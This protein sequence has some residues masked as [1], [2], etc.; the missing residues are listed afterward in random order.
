MEQHIITPLMYILPHST[1]H[2]PLF[3]AF[4]PARYSDGYSRSR[5]TLGITDGSILV[6]PTLIARRLQLVTR[7]YLLI[8]RILDLIVSFRFCQ[9][10]R[11]GF[12]AGCCY[13]NRLALEIFWRRGRGR[14]VRWAKWGWG[15][16][17][18][19]RRRRGR[20]RTVVP[21]PV[22]PVRWVVWWTVVVARGPF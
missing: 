11:L 3:L 21:L 5:S 20:R 16:S 13:S 17:K 6:L 15:R 10:L 14:P 4:V 8:I 18:R 2:R 1:N 22:V 19:R 9:S 12:T 7:V